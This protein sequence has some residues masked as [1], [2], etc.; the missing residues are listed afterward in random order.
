MVGML[1]GWLAD[2]LASW[3]SSW[4]ALLALLLRLLDFASM[5]Y[6]VRLLACSGDSNCL[7]AAFDNTNSHDNLLGSL[8]HELNLFVSDRN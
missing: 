2:W 3:L 1:V 8:A 5:V 6:L 7:A 4:M